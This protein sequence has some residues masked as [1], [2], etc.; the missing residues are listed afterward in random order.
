[1][2]L[3]TGDFALLPNG[4]G[5]AL[6]SDRQGSRVLDADVI[7]EG[8]AG[9][10]IDIAGIGPQTRWLCAGYRATGALP[11]PLLALLPPV[12]HVP[13]RQSAIRPDLTEPLRML[14]R[15]AAADRPGSQIIIDRLID[16]LVVH[17]LREWLLSGLAA[18]L[19]AAL[20]DLAVAT[21]VTALHDELHR[22]WTLDELAARSGLS[23]ATLTRRFTL[24]IGEPPLS[25]LRRRRME[26]AARRLRESDETL[27]VIA[28][29]VGYN[30]EFAFSRAFSRTFGTAPGRYRAATRPGRHHTRS[31]TNNSAAPATAGDEHGGRRRDRRPGMFAYTSA[32][33]G[34]TT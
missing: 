32:T 12:V 20:D 15:E 26:L 19:P 16:I 4:A 28:R 11:A 34:S 24:L 27:S 25:Y 2:R 7:G 17:A 8:A 1:L 6:S 9:S 29:R 33:P 3:G 23:R 14:G 13:A 5:H 18:T 22:P 21:A 30:S 10:E 31:G